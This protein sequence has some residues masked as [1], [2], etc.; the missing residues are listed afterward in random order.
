[1][2]I[3]SLVTLLSI[4]LPAK[5]W[6]AADQPLA[7]SIDSQAPLTLFL[8]DFSGK[9]IQGNAA[10]EVQPAATVD[11]KKI[12]PQVA[13]PGTYLLYAVPQKEATL[14]KFVGTPLVISVRED[15]RRNAPPGA[16]VTKIEPLVYATMTTDQGDMI[17]AF[18]FD[19]APNTSDNFID[20]AKGGYFDGLTFHRI[21]PGF[22]IQGGDPRGDGTGGPGYQIGAEFS[23]RPHVEGTLSMARTGDPAE[24]GGTSPRPE[25]ANSAGSQFFICL[26]YNATKQLDGK[27]TA[28]GKVV[29]GMEVYKAIGTTPADRTSGRPNTPVIVQKVE[30]K[31]VTAEMNPYVGLLDK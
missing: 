9:Q 1:M 31:P 13:Q 5:T 4:L 20:L 12:F 22:V 10:S 7:I 26:D 16:M 2:N 18:Y 11:I 3:V 14:D 8:T 24:G 23:D 21:V 29:K 25:F 17:M 28:F 15:K 30:I 27:Y 19:V 6:F